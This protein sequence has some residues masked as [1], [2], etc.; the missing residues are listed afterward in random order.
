MY[1][2]PFR[3]RAEKGMSTAEYA[4]GTLG[5]ATIAAVLIG[6]G[7]PILTWVHAVFEQVLTSMFTMEPGDFMTLPQVF[8]RAIESLWPW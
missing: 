1:R 8:S 6:P 4:V 7:N 3:T 5:A 2:E